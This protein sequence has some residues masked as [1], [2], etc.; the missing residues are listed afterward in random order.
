VVARSVACALPLCFSPDGKRLASASEDWTVRLWDA[1]KGEEV[2]TLIRHG[3]KSV[4]AVRVPDA[5]KEEV[6]SRD[7]LS[8][9]WL[10]SVRFSP[11]GK[12]LATASADGTV[13]LWNADN[14]QEVLTLRAHTDPVND[15]CF[16]PDGTRLASASDD[17]TVRLW[18]ADKGQ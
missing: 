9:R 15:V 7:E 4:N 3:A 13:R 17:G 16:S 10:R 5:E 12:R 6:L 11:D 18:D 2:G 8:I 14:G 1:D